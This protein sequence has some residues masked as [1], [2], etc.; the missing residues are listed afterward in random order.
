MEIEKRINEIYFFLSIRS[1]SQKISANIDYE[2]VLLK[3]LIITR[4]SKSHI[5]S[6]N[7]SSREHSSEDTFGNPVS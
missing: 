2:I 1:L 7:S 3:A 5:S 6:Y 4:T